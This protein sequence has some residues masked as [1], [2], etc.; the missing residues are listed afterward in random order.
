MCKAV[1][2]A[3][4]PGQ[5]LL[6]LHQLLVLV[7]TTLCFRS[8][9]IPATVHPKHPESEPQS[10]DA[11]ACRQLLEVLVAGEGSLG[12]V[13]GLLLAR[14]CGPCLSMPGVAAHLAARLASDMG[15]QR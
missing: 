6:A 4:L 14:D 8:L 3:P 5:Q 9:T 11:E 1:R 13:R 10:Q 2:C 15:A 12:V 7:R